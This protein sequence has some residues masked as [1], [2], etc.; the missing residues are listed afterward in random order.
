M[1]VKKLVVKN[2]LASLS[3][4]WIEQNEEKGFMQETRVG[5]E[6]MSFLDVAANPKQ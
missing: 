2:N 3:R 4:N 6:L 5:I 1:V